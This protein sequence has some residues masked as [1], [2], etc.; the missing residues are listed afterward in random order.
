MAQTDGLSG[1]FTPEEA[2]K[3]LLLAT[4]LK[5]ELTGPKSV[6]VYDPTSPMAARAQATS[7]TLPTITVQRTTAPQPAA[8]PP[9]PVASAANPN[10]TMALPPA[11]PGGQVAV[12]GRVGILGNLDFMS[13]P[14]NTTSFTNEFTRDIEATSVS[15]VLRYSPSVVAAAA[16]PNAITDVF[17]V[18]GFWGLGT[19][20]DGLPGLEFRQTQLEPIERVEL[21][22]GPSAFIYGQPGAVGGTMNLVPK[23]AGNEPLT[24]IGTRF[25]S[26]QNF[27]AFADI[28]RRY[29]DNKEFGIRVNAA[30]AGGETMVSD[31]HRWMDIASVALDYRGQRFRWTFDFINLNRDVP[32]ESWFDLDVGVPVPRVKDAAREFAP[33]WIQYEAASKLAMTRA[34]FD[35]SDQWTVSAAYGRTWMQDHRVTQ[36]YTITDFGRHSRPDL[37]RRLGLSRK[38]QQL[39]G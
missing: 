28:G 37:L 2:L 21:L 29:G 8:P 5:F 10:T 31:T 23:R 30:A 16:G 36:V 26:R 13:T 19:N 14:F 12:G 20:F 33:K 3:K 38:I 22:L 6:A 18:R 4:P 32:A 1:V 25:I 27:G 11:F 35:L 39:L 17:Y 9:A 34:E 7:S 24:S 15:D